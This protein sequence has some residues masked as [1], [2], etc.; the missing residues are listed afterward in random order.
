MHEYGVPVSR[1]CKLI[2]IPRS[3]FYYERKKDDSEVIE[4]LQEL[5]F[6][7][8]TYGFRKLFAYLRRD[9]KLWNHK[10]V[11]RIYKLLKLNRKRKGKR[12]LPA[13]VKQPLAQQSLVNQS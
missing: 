8:P 2:A 13:R 1:A 12:R 4:A 3:Q 5:A 10:R 11:Y 7:H 9:G 6:K